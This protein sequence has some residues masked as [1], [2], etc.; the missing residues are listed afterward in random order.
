MD[1][2]AQADL[3]RRSV[4]SPTE[5]VEAAIERIEL[6]NDKLNAVITP[7]FE[8]A[9]AEA[10]AARLPDGPFRGVP[11]LLKDILC[12]SAGD[13]TYGGMRAL[14]D[15]DWRAPQDSTLAAR[16]RSAGFVF[17]GKTNLPELATSVTTEPLAH[18]ATR[19]PWD[20]TRSPGGSSGGSAAAVAA[21]MV[22]VAHGNDMA[23]SIRMPASACGVVGLKPT[24]AR[25]T[26]GPRYGEYW[27]AG[28]H[29]HV[30][31][32]SVRDTAAVLDVTAGMAVGDPYTAPLPLRPYREEVGA[33]PGTLRI[34]FRSTP[35]GA[36]T[37]AHEDC[38][39]AVEHT[40]RLLDALGHR[41]EPTPAAA[42]DSPALFEALPT[43]F[44]AILAWELEEWSERL[45]ERLEPADLEPMNGLLAE[46]GRSVTAAQ[47]LSG[48]QAWQ[49]WA[50]G[51]AGLWETDVDV[52]LTPTLPTPPLPL[53]ELAPTAK[54]P[55]ELVAGVTKGIAF[56]LPFNVTGQPAVSLPLYR[57]ADGLPIGVQ[58]VAAYGRED[59]LIRLASQ[60]E[61]AAPWSG[62]RPPFS[63]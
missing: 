39:A 56:T 63:A 54:D 7:L 41:V 33:D 20:L 46:A 24:R 13:P 4:L 27:G 21:G 6:L 47:W 3:V 51:V 31:T 1:A 58:L 60:L 55:M 38:V 30:L 52:L 14:R 9:L 16:F 42:L 26:L 17:C 40:A 11:M 61:Q 59:V 35:P 19:N 53:G 57:N 28:T 25:T 2:T 44:S 10:G 48:V 5:L 8:K 29:E 45:G 34:G 23:G 32:R 22:P 62:E 15:R 50:R 36:T 37:P 43:L 49:Q 12:H 18:G